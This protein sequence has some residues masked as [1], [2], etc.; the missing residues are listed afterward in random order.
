MGVWQ[1]FIPNNT[2][3]PQQSSQALGACSQVLCSYPPSSQLFISLYRE[4]FCR[5]TSL[6]YFFSL[7]IHCFIFYLLAAYFG[8]R[9]T[10][11]KKS[12]SRS[13]PPHQVL[14]MDHPT[15][16]FPITNLGS[17]YLS[18]WPMGFPRLLR[19]HLMQVLSFLKQEGNCTHSGLSFKTSV[20]IQLCNWLLSY[21]GIAP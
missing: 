21:W 16:G 1:S 9:N 3:A 18:P 2:L 8:W 15:G 6:F 17:I 10:D 11:L 4:L 20:R 14:N 7:I 13:I 19:G 5:G 12:I